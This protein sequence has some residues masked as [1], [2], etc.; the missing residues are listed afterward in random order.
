MAKDKDALSGFRALGK[1]LTALKDLDAEQQSWVIA[2]AASNLGISAPV[3]QGSANPGAGIAGGVTKP[4]VGEPGTQVHAKSFMREK[5]PQSDVQRIA[6]LAY[7]L[8][9]FKNTTQFKTSE[10]REMNTYSAGTHLSN[11]SKSVDNATNQNR[12]LAPAGR[13]KKQLTSL[14]ESIVEALPNQEAVSAVLAT[15]RPKKKYK[16]RKAKKVN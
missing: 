13:G 10:I 5:K 2:S 4:A 1:V 11:P 15:D 6:C 12:Y 16:K 7:Y 14:G 3:S 9:N 8:T